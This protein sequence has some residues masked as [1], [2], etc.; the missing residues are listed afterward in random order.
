MTFWKR[1]SSIGVEKIRDFQ[2]FGGRGGE[3]G[4]NKW[5]P[6]IFRVLTLSIQHYNGEHM[7]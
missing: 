7:A 2:E 5:S 3:R 6:G 4:M 1:Q